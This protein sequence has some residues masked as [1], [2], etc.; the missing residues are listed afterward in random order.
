[1]PR[2]GRA[3]VRRLQREVLAV[4]SR[5]TFRHEQPDEPTNRCREP[6]AEDATDILVRRLL[7]REAQKH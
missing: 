3:A 1:M 4:A 5:L 6:G 2:R 7:E